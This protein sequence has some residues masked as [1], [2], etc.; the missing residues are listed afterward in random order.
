MSLKLNTDFTKLPQ[1]KRV[2]LI[3]EHKLLQMDVPG[4]GQ[5]PTISGFIGWCYADD[6]ETWAYHRVTYDGDNIYLR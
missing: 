4:Y 1:G 3:G 6:F 5:P 2:V